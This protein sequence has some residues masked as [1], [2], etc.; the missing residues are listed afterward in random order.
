MKN[1]LHLL[2]LIL[3][4]SFCGYTQTNGD[5]RSN[6]N[7]N[8]ISTTNWQVCT[9][10][11]PVTWSNATLVPTSVAS[12]N[13]ITIQSGHTATSSNVTT[14]ANIVIN[15]TLNVSSNFATG[16]L[17]IN[18]SS[19]RVN[20]QNA[21]TYTVNGNVTVN[22]GGT[23]NANSNPGTSTYFIVYGNYTNNG[24]SD[25]WKANVVIVGNLTSP[26]TSSLQNNGN[27]VV[28][29]NLIGTF[30]FTG[31]DGS[32][33]LYAIDPNATV[34]VTNASNGNTVTPG[35]NLS[36]ENQTLI[37]FVTTIFGSCNAAVS[38][39]WNGISWSNGTPTVA[40]GVTFAANYSGGSIVACN[41]LVNAG[42]TLTINNRVYLNINNGIT[43]NGI[44]IVEDG[45][46]IVQINNTTFS[47]NAISYK[48]KTT[49]L[50]QY[51]YTYWS[52]PVSNP[53][54]G[55]LATNSI[56]Y[57]FSPSINNWVGQ[58]ST[59]TMAAG[60]GYIGRSPSGLNYSTPQIVETTFSGVPNNGV[61]AIPIIKGTGAYNLIGNPYPS[62]ISVDLFI[63]ANSAVT[64]G[65]V[66]FWT[67]NTA[68]T[69]N[70]YTAN[71]YAKYNYT[72]GVGT[73]PDLT[74]GTTPTGNIA[75]GQGFFIEA[76]TSLANGSYSATF[77]NAMRIT[78][79]NTQFFRNANP[80]TTPVATNSISEGLERHRVW[81]SLRNSQGAYNQMLL[82]YVQNATNDF[83][84]LFDGKTLAAGNA[85]SIYTTIGTDDLAIQGRSLP[86]S[87]TDIIPVG[88]STTINGQL[89]IN[90]DNFDGIFSAENIYLYDK[91][92]GIYNDLKLGQYTFTTVS[93]TFNNR[94]ELRFTNTALGVTNPTV[95]DSDI[96]IVS[97]N[98]QIAIYSPLESIEK[99]KVFDVLG[100]LIYS[101]NNVRST[102]FETNQLAIAPQMLIVKI[103]LENSQTIT[104]KTLIN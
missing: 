69:N 79:N 16:A 7:V 54:L 64:N 80:A 104:K 48:R 60:V 68:I 91:T 56:F 46:S 11:T 103:T 94:F 39:T 23:F 96:K 102:I 81:L 57:S 25:F 8:F 17:T 87:N 100:K 41:I 50:K 2:I 78:G 77:N 92:T 52:S 89:N 31:G 4:F 44:I 33:Q 58:A 53:I 15:G 101:Q 93:G 98:N 21:N 71:D 6:G 30:D 75:A 43:N 3:L 86:F 72:G 83:D 29:G 63:A 40:K 62:A 95:T 61:I 13:T 28:G 22:S 47:G 10:L 9:S 1:S 99:V 59:S 5:Y 76:K 34:S 84:T 66:Y 82:G 19:G 97:N 24:T 51:D 12:S 45:G 88:Y 20:L 85:V 70:V 55:Q 73:A 65:T 26:S 36:G 35:T 32:G 67:H 14:V 74:A 37:N 18:G 38:T 27:V 49:P 42:V 90:L